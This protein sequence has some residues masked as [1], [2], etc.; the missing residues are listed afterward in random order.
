MGNSQSISQQRNSAMQ[1][2]VDFDGQELD[3]KDNPIP[4]EPKKR[5]PD[6]ISIITIVAIIG[7]VMYTVNSATKN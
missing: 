1:N 2:Y 6:Y 4:E 3:V 5:T 7:A